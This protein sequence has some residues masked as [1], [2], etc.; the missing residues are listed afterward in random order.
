LIAGCVKPV[1]LT[2]SCKLRVVKQSKSF[3]FW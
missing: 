2:V 1:F 3:Y